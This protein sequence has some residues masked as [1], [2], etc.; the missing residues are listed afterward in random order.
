M[1]ILHTLFDYL[2]WRGD[3]T[4]KESPLN[5]VDS[6]IFCAFSYCHIENLLDYQERK[7][8]ED[9]Y[10]EYQEIEEDNIFKKNQNRLFQ[11]LSKS[12]R[13][14][15]VLVT[16]Y[17]NEVNEEKEMQIAGMTF[18]LPNDTLFVAFKGT[19]E[20]LTGWKEDFALS[21]KSVIPSQEK[22]V[23]YLNEILS[24]TKKHVYV[25]G[26]SKGGNLAMYASLFCQE[27]DKLVQIYN[28][29]GPGFNKEII[30]TKEYQ[31][32]KEKI[33]S[34]IPKA[35]IVGTL[36]NEDTKT[37]IVKSKQLGFLQHDLYSWL[38]LNNHFVYTKELSEDAKNLSNLLNETL[39]KIPNV[40]KE[41]FVSMIFE[42]LESW[43]V[44]D[45]EKGIGNLF[46]SSI[47]QKYNFKMEDLAILYRL[48]PLVVEIMR[49]LI[50]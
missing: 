44:E 39:D 26:H 50:R 19:D 30:D 5:E 32:R 27:F 4:F 16:R 9:L 49:R 45:I 6:L 22:A 37:M 29:D 35:S 13:F 36:F 25:G 46:S 23:S 33:I 24:S 17:F 28:Y 18:I 8:I 31:K 2:E 34:F 48:I 40:Q 20:T 15:D 1:I 11:I 38:V 47:L 14:K 7:T 3:I 21:Y 10:Q 41:K 42:L 43:N 12:N